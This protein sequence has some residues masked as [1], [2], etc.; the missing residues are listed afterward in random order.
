MTRKYVKI[1]DEQLAIAVKESKSIFEVLKYFGIKEAG[2]SHAHYSRRIK[3]LGLNTSH[4]T[5]SRHNVG[6]PALNRKTSS[7]IL[8]KR[9]SHRRTKAHQL[10]RALLEIGREHKC[11]Q[12]GQGPEWRGNSLTLDVDHINEDWSD[13]RAENL[14]FLCPNC[15]SQFS[16]RLI[17]H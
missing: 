12:C 1:T 4:F 2:G 16:R 3:R 11:E 5:G 6:Q 13:D 9:D 17:K 8:V 10:V 14:R 15:H 7:Q